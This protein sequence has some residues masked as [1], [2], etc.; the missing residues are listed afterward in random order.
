G[1]RAGAQERA[2]GFARRRARP[3]DPRARAP[4]HRERAGR[5]RVVE[6][7]PAQGPAQDD[8]RQFERARAPARGGAVHHLHEVVRGADPEDRVSAHRCRAARAGALPGPHGSVDS[9]HPSGVRFFLRTDFMPQS[10]SLHLAIVMDGNGRWATR[11]GLPRVAGHRAGAEAVRCTVEA[12]PGLG[13]AALTLYAFS[14]DN[15]KRPAAEVA[16]LMRLLA[17]YLRT[18]TPRL[19]RN[20]VRLELIGRRDRLPGPLLA[21]IG[22]AE[23]ATARSARLHLRLAVDY[24]S[25]WAIGAGAALGIWGDVLLRAVPWGL[26][27][28]LCTAGLVAAAAGL[29]R[30]HRVAVSSDAPWLAA[31]A[32]IIASNFVARDSSPLRAFD[33]IGLTIVFAVA[34]LSIHGVGLRGIQAWHYVRACFDAALSAWLGVFPLVGRDVTWS[35]LPRGGRLRQLRGAALGGLLAF[36][37]LVVFGG[38]FSS[39]DAVFHDVVADAFAIDFGAVLGHIALFGILTVLAAGYLRGALLRAAPS[40]SLTE[41]D[42]KVA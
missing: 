6:L 24:S 23:H 7:Q 12:A 30:R 2:R 33:T 25:R 11:R 39:A 19:A 3:A 1:G 38:L 20:D 34:F 8:G 4:R 13:V 32:L 22:A 5:Q 28:L 10:S 31:A 15:W 16:A 29:A 18:E 9:R 21:A 35:E 26:N 36:P 41:G 42:S 14:A 27:A 37:L 40:R 17:R